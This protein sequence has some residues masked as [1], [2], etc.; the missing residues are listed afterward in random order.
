[1]PEA[2]NEKAVFLWKVTLLRK[3][4][5]GFWCSATILENVKDQGLFVMD[6]KFRRYDV[7]EEGSKVCIGLGWIGLGYCRGPDSQ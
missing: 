1:V 5:R 6:I 7:I 4:S 2:L 3:L